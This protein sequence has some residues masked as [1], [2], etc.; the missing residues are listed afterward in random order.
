VGGALCTHQ[1]LAGGDTRACAG[2]GE[3]RAL[4]PSLQLGAQACVAARVKQPVPAREAGNHERVVAHVVHAAP[5]LGLVV[6]FSRSIFCI[7]VLRIGILQRAAQNLTFGSADAA[8]RGR[9]DERSA[10]RVQ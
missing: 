1:A 8:V 9:R 7:G 6:F 3:L 5:P 4:P 2:D 10:A